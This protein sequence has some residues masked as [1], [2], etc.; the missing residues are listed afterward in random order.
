MIK[1]KQVGRFRVGRLNARREARKL[2]VIINNQEKTYFR[3]LNALFRKYLRTS[4][5]LYEEFGR[6]EISEGAARLREEFFPMTVTHFRKVFRV[7]YDTNNKK[8]KDERDKVLN[9]FRESLNDKFK[10][11]HTDQLLYFYNE[12]IRVKDANGFVDF[13]D[14]LLKAL[15]PTIDFPNYKV[16]LV[17]EVQDLSRLEWQVIS[18]I[19]RK[20]EELFLVGDDDQAIY[21]WKGSNVSIFQKWPCQKQNVIKLETSHRLPGKIY[22]L[23]LNIRSNIK[24]RLGNEFSCKK[25]I[26]PKIKDEGSINKIVNLQELDKVIKH[27]SDVIFCSRAKRNCREYASYLK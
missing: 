20:T 25:R 17:D 11:V 2:R 13:D 24:T 21:G 5:F 9:Y 26:D 7:I 16:V 6:Y 23:A 4:A 8:F 3:R 10:F 22:D 15:Q 19:G 14:M 1:T 18:K 27:D 12:L